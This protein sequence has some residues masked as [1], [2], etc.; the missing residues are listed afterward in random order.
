MNTNLFIFM[1]HIHDALWVTLCVFFRL[2]HPFL[3]SVIL[4]HSSIA[5]GWC[6]CMWFESMSSSSSFIHWRKRLEIIYVWK[7]VTWEGREII[8][9][10]LFIF[11]FILFSLQ[12]SKWGSQHVLKQHPSEEEKKNTQNHFHFI[13][14]SLMMMMKW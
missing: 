10:Y 12:P 8:F 1:P 13:F 9:L 5:I 6:V 14:I 11:Y 7:I 4:Y 3:P 2:K